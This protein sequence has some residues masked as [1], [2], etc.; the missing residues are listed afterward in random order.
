[1]ERP[2]PTP[3]P[4]SQTA[5]T[6]PTERHHE[7]AVRHRFVGSLLGIFV[8]DALGMPVEGLASGAISYRHGL[9]RDMLEARLGKGTYTDDTEM[10]IA[11]AQSLVARRGFDGAHMAAG[12]VAG[13]DRARG[14]G[15]GTLEALDRVAAG[16]PWQ[17][18]GAR[19]YGSGSFGNGSAS[20][21]GPVGLL[22]HRNVHEAMETA[23]AQ[24]D[25]THSHP[26]GRAGAAVMAA[27]VALALRWGTESRLPPEPASFLQ[28]IVAGLQ[29]HEHLFD[30]CLDKVV[31][32][33]EQCPGLPAEAGDEERGHTAIRVAAVLGNDSRSFHSVPAAFYS[34]LAHP[35]DPEQ[36]LITAVSLGGDTDTIAA[37]AGA[38]CGAYRGAEAWPD[39]WMGALEQ[40]PRGRDYVT[41]L[42]DDLFL[43]WLEIHSA[44]PLHPR[45]LSL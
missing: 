34:F 27:G 43:T 3:T 29:D 35:E 20:R 42:A 37:M 45:T 5:G 6:T 17:R 38:L 15:R 19:I 11:V 24:S 28:P 31:H 22:L 1:M 13:L 23:R 10:A 44:E 33:L 36:A 39:R 7:E 41:G 9:V 21:A 26:L 32:V 2:T 25:I 4:A 18:A 8:G 30:E 40:G 16:V 12:L 14:Y